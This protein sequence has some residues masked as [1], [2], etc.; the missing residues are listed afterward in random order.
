MYQVLLVDDDPVQLRVREALLR[1]AGL[2]VTIVTS[3]E[4]A[5]AVLRSPPLAATVGVIVTDH[6]LPG[7]TGA[8]FVRQLRA[9]RNAVPVIVLSGLAEAEAEYEGLNVVF[10]TKP[11]PPPELIALLR[12]HLPQ[13]A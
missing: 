9:A 8:D 7:V 1:A 12:K 5:L 6:V 10:R 13:A 3:A 2:A 11:F 4:A